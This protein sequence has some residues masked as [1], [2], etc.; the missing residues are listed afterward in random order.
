MKILIIQ[1][2]MI[3]DVLTSSI[4]FE[5]LKQKYPS[6]ELH[7]LI[8]EHTKPVVEN[9]P[10]IDKLLLFSSKEESSSGF[11]NFLKEIKKEQYDVVIDVYAKLNSALISFASGAPT[12]ISYNKWYSKYAYTHTFLQK[13]KLDT[14][15]GFA[16]ENRMLLLTALANDFPLEIKPKIYLTASEKENARSFLKSQNINLN[17]P[18][19]MVSVLGSAANKTY[20]P[21]YLAQLL[22]KAV[23]E[24]GAQ[25]LFNYIPKQKEEAKEVFDLCKT[26]TQK[27]IFFNIFGRNLREFLSF[28]ANCNALIGNE[29]GAVNMAKALN[30]P[31]FAIF[32]PWI[33]KEAWSLYEDECN[34]SVHLKD[35]KPAI[36]NS[37]KAKKEA[38][39]LYKVFKPQLF[40]DKFFNFLN[41]CM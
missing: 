40:Q 4:L 41:K 18:L 22:D 27:H 20:P 26:E 25:L 15:A 10:F 8:Y 28:T 34:V 39:D 21:A 30:I 12:R 11:F 2:K 23:E 31:T 17:K 32:S 6:A 29:G 33:R 16:V 13:K 9:N 37:M 19:I 7:Y 36:F 38:Q 24:T 14:N 35:Y 5:A 3:G 1:Q